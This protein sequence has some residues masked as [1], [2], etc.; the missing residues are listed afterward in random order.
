M[1]HAKKPLIYGRFVHI[2]GGTSIAHTA[3]GMDTWRDRM[4]PA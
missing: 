3:G 4:D 2:H 1:N